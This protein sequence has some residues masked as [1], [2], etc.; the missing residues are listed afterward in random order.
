MAQQRAP[1]LRMGFESALGGGATSGQNL[2]Y[3]SFTPGVTKGKSTS[4]VI[5]SD[6]NPRAPYNE[7][8]DAS[9]SLDVPVDTR[10]MGYLLKALMGAPTTTDNGDG[11]YTHE[12][13]ILESALPSVEFEQVF[14][15]FDTDKF[16]Q[17]LGCKGNSFSLQAG[18][19]GELTASFGFLGVK[20]Q[21]ASTSFDGTATDAPY[22]KLQH[23]DATLEMDGVASTDRIQ[24]LA[25]NLNRNLD[26]DTYTIGGGGV[27]G[28]INEQICAVNGSI[29]ALFSDDT[30]VAKG[31]NDTESSIKITW[32]HSGGEYFEIE[33]QELQ[34]GEQLPPVDGPQGLRETHDFEAYYSDGAEASAIVFR[35]MNNIASY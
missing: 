13:K 3:L 31:F 17:V 23:Q 7:L 34:Y 4:N 24:T 35:L 14:D 27:R 25:I 12:F 11:T 28:S 5:S 32:T 26:G 10:Q 33:L 8:K 21:L 29:T 22:N 19:S 2:S 20:G 6:L 30:Y 15:D 18:A 1:K 9:P 16:G